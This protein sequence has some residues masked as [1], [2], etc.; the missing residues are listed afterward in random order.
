MRFT[1]P[2]RSFDDSI[3]AIHRIHLHLHFRTCYHS[4]PGYGFWKH[5]LILVLRLKG[6]IHGFL[7]SSTS[8]TTFIRD[9]PHRSR[10]KI[11]RTKSRRS[12]RPFFIYL[13]NSSSLASKDEPS[14]VLNLTYS[15][16]TISAV[17]S[18]NR[19]RRHQSSGSVGPSSSGSPLSS[20][21][22]L[23]DKS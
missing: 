17:L 2:R 21:R 19:S 9:V 4:T 22:I 3:S 23:E 20:E 18:S 8:M 16:R 11:T 7:A 13:K 14:S 12:A 6:S 1:Y 10:S 5:S 15:R